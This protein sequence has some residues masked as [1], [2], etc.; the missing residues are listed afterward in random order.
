MGPSMDI[1]TGITMG[2]RMGLNM[3]LTTCISMG[4]KMEKHSFTLPAIDLSY[5]RQTA[6]RRQAPSSTPSIS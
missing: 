2:N 4:I 5:A 6:N 3:G 1:A